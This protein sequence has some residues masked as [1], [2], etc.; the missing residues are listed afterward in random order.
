ME[1]EVGMEDEVLEEAV[2]AIEVVYEE[3]LVPASNTDDSERISE[4]LRKYEIARNRILEWL[5]WTPEAYR[6]AVN[7][8]M[9]RF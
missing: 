1:H 8:R 9:S 6:S 4:A 3:T 2:H 5:G 7:H